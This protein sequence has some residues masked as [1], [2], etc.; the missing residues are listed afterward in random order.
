[1]KETLR[2]GFA[3]MRGSAGAFLPMEEPLLRKSYALPPAPAKGQSERTKWQDKRRDKRQ[4]EQ[5]EERRR[6]GIGIR[7]LPRAGRE[8]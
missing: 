7:P 8:L 4:E 6:S 3:K 2:R 1:M 5:K